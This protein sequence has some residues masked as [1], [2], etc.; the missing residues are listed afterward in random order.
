MCCLTVPS[1]TRLLAA[2]LAVL[3]VAGFATDGAVLMFHL[4]TV[5]S[6]FLL[7]SGIVGLIATKESEAFARWYLILV[8]VVY[9]LLAADG[10]M[11]GGN[12]VQLFS[13]N[14]AENYL[15][16]LVAVVALASGLS[17][18]DLAKKLKI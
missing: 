8:G 18:K 9:G 3:G 11:Y 10:F 15:H 13:V 1:T 12:T 5:Q 17:G 2:V 6:L 7:G 4:D 14:E 16:L